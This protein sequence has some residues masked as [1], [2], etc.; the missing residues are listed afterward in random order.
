MTSGEQA[1][2]ETELE[3][4][5]HVDRGDIDEQGRDARRI[6]D[7]GSNFTWLYLGKVNGRG[8]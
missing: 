7:P 1:E 6:S 3:A 2:C 5:G 8:D 4:S